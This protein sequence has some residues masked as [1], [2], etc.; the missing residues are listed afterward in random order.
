MKC[1]LVYFFVVYMGFV[2]LGI[3]FFIDLGV[4]GVV[5]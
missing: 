5:L 3:V 4:S 2:L 1:C